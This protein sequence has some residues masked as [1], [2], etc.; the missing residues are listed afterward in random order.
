MIPKINLDDRTFD[1]IFND[2]LKL[3]PRYCPEWTNHNASDPGITLLELFSWMTEMTI[4][5]LNK[6]PEKTYLS[7]LELMGL[8]LTTPQSARSIVQFFPVEGINKNIDVRAGTQIA[9][10]VSDAADIVFE[11][12]KNIKINNNKLV[13]CVNRFKES[14]KENIENERLEEF[15]LFESK[16]SVEHALY[17]CS[18]CFRHL[19]AEHFVQVE[20]APVADIVKESD[21]IVRHLA[22]ECWDGE[23]WSA[24]KVSS[25]VN[26]C[27][28]KDNVVYIHGNT[29]IQPTEVNGEEGFWIRAVLSDVPEKESTLCAKG[30]KLKTIFGGNGFL[31]DSCVRS[32]DSQYSQ[33]DM[34]TAFSLF[35]DNP[36]VNETFYICADEIFKNKKVSVAIS[37]TFAETS[38]KV[39]DN[40]NAMFI[41]EY[42]NGTDWT[43]LAE[44]NSFKDGTFNLKQGG[45]VSFVMPDDISLG[46]VNNEE[47][48]W[49]R[50]RLVTKD[51]ATGGVYYK[52]VKGNWLWKFSSKVQSPQVEKIRIKYES[53]KVSP[54]NV[55]AYSN[56]EWKNLK[57]FTKVRCGEEVKIFSLDASNYPSLY[58]GF[59]QKFPDGESSVY[60][61]LNE[62]HSDVGRGSFSSLRNDVFLP[63][64]GRS[65]AKL[66]WEYFNGE[67][68]KEL[69]VNDNTD[70]FR[71]SGFVDFIVPSDSVSSENFGKNLYW[72][73]VSLISGSF[74]NNPVVK[75][76]LINSVY[77]KNEKTYENE[78]LGSGTGAPGQSLSVAHAD[79]LKG[80]VLYV[81]EGS[82]PS[83]NELDMI[84][85]DCGGEPYFTDGDK[86]WV[87]YTEVENFYASN[88]FSRHYV[89]DYTTG[90]IQF[91]DG[92]KGVNPPKGK[93]NVMMKSYHTGGGSVGNVA[94]NTI[95]GLLKGIPFV[96]GCTNPYPAE[97]GADMEG[98]DSLKARA[99]GSFKS[100]QRAVTSEDFKWLALESSSSVG[101]AHCLKHRNSKNEVCTVIVPVRASG[102]GYDTKL[103]P[104]RELIR[105][106]KEYLDERKIVGTPICV[107]GP[108]YKDFNIVVSVSFKSSVFDEGKT[109]KKIEN[110]LLRYF[111]GLDGEDGSGW[112]F[113]KEL[114]NGSVLKQLEKIDEILTINRVEL[115]DLDA[116]VAVEKI[117]LKEYE[118]PFLNKVVIEGR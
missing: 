78:I 72:Y 73:R 69:F 74:E 87:R 58:L 24:L 89:V 32:H 103:V 23:K 37:Y 118:L 43:K 113:G 48:Y 81:D 86:V 46:T 3:I 101:R 57:P 94:R 60:F 88:A 62:S 93:F 33:V 59:E 66:V 79:I 108:V 38:V 36:V 98:V 16:N 49:I 2:A 70:N 8:S 10:S 7:L 9:A 115:F 100:L 99:A 105:R 71:E 84:R 20:F 1:D 104:S 55:F 17:I 42:W 11:T 29:L 80:S 102:T 67:G 65:G 30:M 4:Y 40:K 19:E 112:T 41:Y 117:L 52:D 76:I 51:Y 106:V 95:R 5:R 56:F 28:K 15:S 35:S 90:R 111:D 110:N 75:D 31:P 26:N 45:T 109:K 82:V 53:L 34:N 61:R 13:S 18:D 54:Q 47:H 77:V 64:R 107:Q 91:G 22:W 25:S 68:W 92:A 12:E 44:K 50:I 21:Q 116:N 97:G 27:K 114:S 14:I 85:K 96:S 39:D 6:V 63:K 83:T